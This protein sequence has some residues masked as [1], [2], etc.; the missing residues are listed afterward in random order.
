MRLLGKSGQFFGGSLPCLSQSGAKTEKALCPRWPT[1]PTR[2][3][4]QVSTEVGREPPRGAGRTNQG[5][6]GA[7]IVFS[8]TE[9][10]KR[11]VCAVEEAVQAPAK[12]RQSM[13]AASR[14]GEDRSFSDPA[15]TGSTA[16]IS[17][18]LA[19]Q[20]ERERPITC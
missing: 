14:S 9:C 6:R 15:A 12:K 11:R 10:Q 2:R 19:V 17:V 13:Q 1:A 7:P 8:G 5:T 20:Q 3:R 4:R 16:T 18:V